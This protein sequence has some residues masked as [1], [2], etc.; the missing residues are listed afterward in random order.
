M[1]HVRAWS[2]AVAYAALRDR[3]RT[4]VWLDSAFV[5]GGSNALRVPVDPQF[6]FLRDDPRYRAWEARV[7]LT[8]MFARGVT[9]SV[10]TARE[11]SRRNR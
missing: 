5:G 10:R 7:G 3:D 2:Y 8:S 4:L 6:D 9:G 11:S 1:A